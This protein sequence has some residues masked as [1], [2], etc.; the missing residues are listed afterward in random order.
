MPPWLEMNDRTRQRA[1]DAW[2]TLT[3]E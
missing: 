3:T 2:F 1:I